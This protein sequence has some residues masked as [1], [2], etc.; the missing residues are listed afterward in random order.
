MVGVTPILA[1]ASITLSWGL[2]KWS[3][4]PLLP[5]APLHPHRVEGGRHPYLGALNGPLAEKLHPGVA[6]VFVAHAGDL[7]MYNR[8]RIGRAYMRASATTIP[9]RA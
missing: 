6:Q 3:R 8:H 9:S 7:R 1:K 2:A 5:F 4:S